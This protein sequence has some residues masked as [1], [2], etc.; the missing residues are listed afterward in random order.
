[1]NNN[2]N[3]AI[4]D[5]LK[6]QFS[7]SVTSDSL[8]PHGLQ[9]ARLPCPSPTPG[10][11]SNSC[12]LSR[13]CHPTISFSVIPFLLLP[14]S[15]FPTIRVFSNESVLRIGN[16]LKTKDLE[17]VKDGW[18]KRYAPFPCSPGPMDKLKK[19][20][21]DNQMTRVPESNGRAWHTVWSHH[22]RQWKS[23]QGQEKV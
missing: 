14:P 1:M 13:W 5:F 8:W 11:Y 23:L 20:Q 18:P 12:P 6:P 17:L 4:I 19:S 9:H 16:M 3:L 22:G 7:H 2:N 10:A 21:K 15:V